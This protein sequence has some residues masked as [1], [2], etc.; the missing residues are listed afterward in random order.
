MMNTFLVYY[1]KCTL[2]PQ[3]PIPP[4]ADVAEL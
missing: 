2:K 1:G 3:E 4:N